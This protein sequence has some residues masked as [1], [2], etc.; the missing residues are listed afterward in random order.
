MSPTTIS[1][2][3]QRDEAVGAAIFVDDQRHLHAARLHRGE[4]Q[5]HRHRRRH[6]QDVADQ[7]ESP[8]VLGQIDIGEIERPAPPFVLPGRRQPT[9]ARSG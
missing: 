9:C 6:E 4:Q 3:L 8:S 5:W 7:I 2:I 1:T